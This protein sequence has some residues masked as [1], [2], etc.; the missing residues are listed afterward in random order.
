MNLI[1]HLSADLEAKLRE[2]AQ[3]ARKAPEDLALE[4]L[5]EKFADE[6]ASSAMLPPD[7]WL[8]EF[9]AFTA[10]SPRGNVN[11]DISRESIYEGRGE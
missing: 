1:L 11:A 10:A 4:A 2:Q 9:R 5:E 8:A 7:V 6:A 3:A